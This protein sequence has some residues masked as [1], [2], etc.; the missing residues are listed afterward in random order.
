MSYNVKKAAQVVGFLVAKSPDKI[1]S[2]LKVV[3]LVYLADRMSL[4][5]NGYPILEDSYVSMPY[6]PVNSQTLNCINGAVCDEN[7]EWSDILRDRE[8]HRISLQEGI[9]EDWDEL[10]E[11]EMETLEQVWAN[12]GHMT[13][14]QLVE[15]T[16]DRNNIPEWENPGRTS[17]DIPIERIM[18]AVGIDARTQEK[19][20]GFERDDRKRKKQVESICENITQ[21]DFG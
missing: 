13:K 14:W 9:V 8:D 11:S 21:A 20:R 12:F 5:E 1:I 17:K 2:V 10:S 4:Q 3:K 16:H 19:A 6:G 7:S 15:W 18:Q